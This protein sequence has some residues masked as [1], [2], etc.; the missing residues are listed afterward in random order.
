[1]Q[2]GVTKWHPLKLKHYHKCLSQ[3][4]YLILVIHLNLELKQSLSLNLNI[5]QD[6][7]KNRHVS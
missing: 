7:Y 5:N 4:V 3:V 6:I 1:M 2:L